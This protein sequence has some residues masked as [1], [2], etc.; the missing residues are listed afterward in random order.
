MQRTRKTALE[1]TTAASDQAI[2]ERVQQGDK[3]AYNILVLRYQHKVCDIAYKYVNNYVDAND[4]AQESFIRAYRALANF[5]GES[6]FYT[7]LYRIVSNTAKSYLEQN[8][9]HRYSVDVDDPEFD[10]QQDVKGLLIS[11]DSP[12]ALLESD[13]L[14]KIV[15][16]AMEDLPEDLKRAIVLREVEEMS[17]EDIASIM[18]TPIGTVRSRIFRARQFIEDRLAQFSQ[19]N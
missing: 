2:V 18:D 16:Q 3:E 1:N 11:N 10:N 12:D 14:H 13:E 7:W 15:S 9:K 4:I 19:G 8:Q 5:R 6:S 17:Y